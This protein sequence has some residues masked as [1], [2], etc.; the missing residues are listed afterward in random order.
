[1][2]TLTAE[3]ILTLIDELPAVEQNRFRQLWDAP[4]TP[5]ETTNGHSHKK[6]LDKR[7]PPIASPEEMELGMVS[8]RWVTQHGREY[9][10]QW[11]ALEGDRL[12]AAGPDHDEV[13]KASQ[14]DGAKMPFITFVED[15][16]NITHIIWT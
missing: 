7:I 5:D 10:N 1:M 15:P 16:D 6:Q 9:K 8:I 12:I 13:W 3:N 2:S 4:T 11:V 14:S